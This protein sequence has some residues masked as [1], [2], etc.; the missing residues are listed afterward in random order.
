MTRRLLHV[1]LACCCAAG[2]GALTTVGCT[3]DT[4]A[5][6]NPFE[7]APECTGATIAPLTGSRVMVISSLKIADYNEGFDF[8]GDG[9]KDNKL[10]TLGA[11]ANS[12]I[13][14]S[15]TTKH[16]VVIPIELFGYE[17][18]DS[19]CTKAAFYLGRFNE[20]RDDDGADSTWEHDK[21]DCNDHN[22][23]V[24]PGKPEV[25]GNR[26][27][28]D[29]DGY[30][31][32]EK[33]G[34]APADTMDMD[35]DGVTLKLGDCNDD[36]MDPNAKSIKRGAT[37][38][39]G[40]GL[41]EDCDGVA[42]ND[43]LCDPFLDNKVGFHVQALSFKD[44]PVVPPGGTTMAAGFKPYITFPSGKVASNLLTAGPDLFE[45]NLAIE[46]FDLKLTLSG[47]HLSFRMKEMNGSYVTEGFL[48]GVLSVVS[49][50]Q[51][52]I[53]AKGIISKE[54]SLADAVFVGAASSLLGIDSDKDGHY[55]PDIDVDG[56]GMETFWQEGAGLASDGGSK[57]QIIDSCKDGDGTVVR[58][59]DNGVA[60]CPMAKDSS[61]KYRFV[62]GLSTTLKIK[63]VPAKLIDVV[64]K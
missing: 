28:D 31:D 46:D 52:H 53:E 34:S 55:H 8:N 56:D 1:F 12:Q 2:L 61:G 38:V 64:V 25:M 4:P 23:E 6:V 57:L 50:A 40:N 63:A 5:K 7:P 43:T 16:D 9:K 21:G 47:A 3:N 59:G 36:P 35:G 48:G 30:A 54:Q 42:D 39:C 29:C 11:L 60:Y 13:D 45:L 22:K 24:R 18:K 17:G 62:D 41:D 27:D 19:A 51:I 32:N 26:I 58:N 10:S 14:D 15:F 33:K 44:M 37:D 49:L 20:D